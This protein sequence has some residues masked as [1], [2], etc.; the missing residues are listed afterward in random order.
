MTQFKNFDDAQANAY[1]DERGGR[2]GY[3]TTIGRLGYPHTVP[4]TYFRFGN[5]VYVPGRR[6]SQRL[7]NIARDPR[8]SFLVEDG[9]TMDSFR[10]LLIQGDATVI[11]DDVEK[12]RIARDA[13]RERGLPEADWPAEPPRGTLIRI[14][15][16]RITSWFPNPQR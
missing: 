7:A 14:E 2:K 6:R 9:D 13:A 11:D 16:R 4:L 12:L 3:L 10:G 5:D 1:L 8:V 15:R